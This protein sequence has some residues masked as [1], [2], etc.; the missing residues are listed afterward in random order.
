[1]KT[2]TVFV[3]IEASKPP[4]V[5]GIYVAIRDGKREDLYYSGSGWKLYPGRTDE[6]DFKDV[7][8][9]LKE[10]KDVYVLTDSDLETIM[11]EAWGAG[12]GYGFA[13]GAGI[14]DFTEHPEF[15]DYYKSKLNP[16]T[17]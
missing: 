11:R 9:W 16:S 4:E 8:H 5:S 14:E 6:K 7:T 10:I 13:S 15:Y 2:S 3:P 12:H 1:M 17:P